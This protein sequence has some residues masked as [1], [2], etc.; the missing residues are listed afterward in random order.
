MGKFT[1]NIR[2]VFNPNKQKQI[3]FNRQH[4]L[5]DNARIIPMEQ[6]QKPHD[7]YFIR[8]IDRPDQFVKF[9]DGS[10]WTGDG[11]EMACL[12]DWQ[13]G[14]NFIKEA[15]SNYEMVRMDQILNR[16]LETRNS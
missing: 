12:W 13:T 3:D 15:G 14:Q 9:K 8:L 16:P 10:Y 7:A 11:P 6:M 5:K 1:D 2:R 4:G